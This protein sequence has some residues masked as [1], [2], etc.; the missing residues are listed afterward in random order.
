MPVHIQTF[1]PDT[2]A[3]ATTETPWVGHTAIQVD[4]TREK[5]N[6]VHA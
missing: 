6:F 4:S 2:I 5:I 3:E 1:L